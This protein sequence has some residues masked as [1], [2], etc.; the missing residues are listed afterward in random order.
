MH[1]FV[2]TNNYTICVRTWIH[3][4]E[5]IGHSAEYICTFVYDDING[6]AYFLR[7]NNPK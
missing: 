3:K 7:K 1:I 6:T 5:Y 4:L 2:N